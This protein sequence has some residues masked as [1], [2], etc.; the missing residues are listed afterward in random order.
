M[1]EKLNKVKENKKMVL[2]V[3]GNDVHFDDVVDVLDSHGN[4]KEVELHGYNTETGEYTH[5]ALG[6]TTC[7]EVVE[8]F[9]DT[10]EELI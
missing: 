9:E 10:V 5:S 8:V 6:L 2:N 3:N 1:K 7:D 4:T